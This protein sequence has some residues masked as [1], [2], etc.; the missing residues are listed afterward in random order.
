MNDIRL[1]LKNVIG[2]SRAFWGYCLIVSVQGKRQASGLSFHFRNHK[3]LKR[4][5]FG[6]H[7]LSRVNG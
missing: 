2:I 7:Y 3:L 6:I 5:D 1:A 4:K